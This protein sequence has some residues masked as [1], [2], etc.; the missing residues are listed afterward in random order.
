MNTGVADANTET[1]VA[2]A[3]AL[4][5]SAIGIVR[6]S[7]PN[8]KRIAESLCNTSFK[9]REAR[10]CQFHDATI[11]DEIIDN[12]IVIW[13]P[14]PNS[15]TGEDV[16][17]MQ[18]HGSPV[19]LQLI[20]SACLQLGARHAKPGEFSERA[21]LNGKLD[22]VQAEAIAD[23]IESQTEAS[24]KHAG[25]SLQG[26][27]S[28]SVDSL[29]QQL[30]A[31]RAYVEGGLDFSEEELDLLA[32]GL[33]K[34]KLHSLIHETKQ[35]LD[36][37]Q[38]A[39]LLQH[40]VRVAI[41]GKPNVGKSTLINTLAG[42]EIAIVTEVAGTTRDRLETVLELNGIP[43]TL[44]DTAGIRD[45]DDYVEQ[46]GIARSKAEISQADLVLHIQDNRSIGDDSLLNQIRKPGGSRVIEVINKQDLFENTPDATDAILI[47][48]KTGKGIDALLE[49]MSKNISNA[50]SESTSV[51]R[52]RHVD[53]LRRCHQALIRGEK[54]VSTT[55]NEELLA[56]ELR[57]AQDCLAEIT[58]EYLPDD[59]LGEIFSR[60]CIGK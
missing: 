29:L 27:F 15:F 45:S 18:T 59:L 44:V 42:R 28:E 17:E 58:G 24:V 12:G 57:S 25:R 10:Y 46:Q 40:G 30:V 4:G 60:F 48:A 49:A 20:Q 37:T 41:V 56:E 35:L 33:V 16:V 26:V 54:H 8:A 6:M 19:V 1:I 3:T 5:K 55:T 51:A 23:I 9:P 39:A 34:D 53:A 2:I 31:L 14:G 22:L 21:Y 52:S 50:C 32:E 13:F 7:G 36:N 38:Y 43:V 47:S 11:N